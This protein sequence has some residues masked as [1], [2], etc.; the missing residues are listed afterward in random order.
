MIRKGNRG[1][2]EGGK[3]KMKMFRVLN[4]ARKDSMPYLQATIV[5]LAARKVGD[6]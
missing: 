6:K 1:L 5:V 2:H 3:V 4:H